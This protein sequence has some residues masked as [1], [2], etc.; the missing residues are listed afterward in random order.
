[1][2]R[3]HLPDMADDEREQFA[4]FATSGCK[5][6]RAGRAYLR[7]IVENEDLP[8]HLAEFQGNGAQPVQDRP[9]A[10][11]RQGPDC[12]HGQPDGAG[13]NPRSGEPW[14]P[15]CRKEARE[16]MPGAQS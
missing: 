10:G 6:R 14:C 8:A 9:A 3:A 11:T 2:L 15:I 13:I 7:T 12:P 1:M 5:N 16:L 4:E